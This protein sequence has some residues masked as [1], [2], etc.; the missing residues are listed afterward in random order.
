MAEEGGGF[1][2]GVQLVRSDPGGVGQVQ[3]DPH[4]QGDTA[5]FRGG[6]SQPVA[7]EVN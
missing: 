5:H 4:Q 2:H 3:A 7:T 1:G 6:D